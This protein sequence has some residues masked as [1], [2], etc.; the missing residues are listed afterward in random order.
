MQI[1]AIQQY[2]DRAPKG[3]RL[4]SNEQTIAPGDMVFYA[5]SHQRDACWVS[6]K[7]G[8]GIIGTCV[9][10]HWPTMMGLAVPVKK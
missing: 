10:D 7:I 3:F 9:H 8:E 5:S 4:A 2:A 1:E 6:P